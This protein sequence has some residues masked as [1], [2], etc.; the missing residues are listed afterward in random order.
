MS[1][2]RLIT[3]LPAQED[4]RVVCDVIEQQS[5]PGLIS[6][7]PREPVVLAAGESIVLELNVEDLR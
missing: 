3:R 7:A 4:R 5:W 6:F 2:M 1:V